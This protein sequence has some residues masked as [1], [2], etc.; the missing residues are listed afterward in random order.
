[1]GAFSRLRTLS[2]ISGHKIVVQFKHGK[3]FQREYEIGQVI[4]PFADDSSEQIRVLA[5]GI[6]PPC[7]P[8]EPEYFKVIVK[9]GRILGIEPIDEAEHDR[10]EGIF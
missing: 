8:E 6:E 1:M 7:S 9:G 5:G 3:D 10:I 4:E 2:P